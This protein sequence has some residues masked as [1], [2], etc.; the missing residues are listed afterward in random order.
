MFLVSHAFALLFC[1]NSDMLVLPAASPD[2]GFAF[3]CTGR[4]PFFFSFLPAASPTSVKRG[5]YLCIVLISSY[6]WY[7]AI[8]GTVRKRGHHCTYCI[9]CYRPSSIAIASR[10]I[11]LIAE[12]ERGLPSNRLLI[13]LSMKSPKSP[14]F[15]PLSRLASLAP[16]EEEAQ[17]QAARRRLSK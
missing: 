4:G 17:P 16:P 6:P 1:P 9:D 11:V 13:A 7:C 2:S 14:L 8:Y 15:L 10:L 5:H 12:R 3:S